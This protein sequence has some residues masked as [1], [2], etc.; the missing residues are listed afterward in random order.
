MNNFASKRKM[1]K[2]I[3]HS[4][5]KR[6]RRSTQ[7]VIAGF[8]PNSA[9]QLWKEYILNLGH[10]LLTVIN[11]IKK[12]S[13]LN[14]LQYTW[15]FFHGMTL[16]GSI[17]YGLSSLNNEAKVFVL[18]PWYKLVL[19]SSIMTY[20]IV[21]YTSAVYVENNS[22]ENAISFSRED[23]RENVPLCR[24]LKSENTYLFIYACL[25]ACTPPHII[26]ISSFGIY[27]FL[28][29]MNYILFELFPDR[30]FSLCLAPL[31]KYIESPLLIMSAHLD[32]LALILLSKGA[33]AQKSFNSLIFYLFIWGLRVEYSEASR[34]AISNILALIN[35]L[36]L[37]SII[38]PAIQNSWIKVRDATRELFSLNNAVKLGTSLYNDISPVE[39]KASSIL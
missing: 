2:Q 10:L 24:I 12:L 18:F 38:P 14:P 35:S 1:A 5:D 19:L 33:Y 31:A 9:F 4:S 11:N 34:I 20:G 6:N 28:N 26:K 27:S 13:S 39:G 32:L 21:I 30:Q 8:D 36:L 23:I 15:L 25:W 3:D 17:M 7:I 29:L 22:T 16:I 37:N